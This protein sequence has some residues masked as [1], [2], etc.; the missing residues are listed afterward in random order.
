MVTK[1][2]IAAPDIERDSGFIGWVMATM[3]HF[4]PSRG[5]GVAHD[6]LE[7]L[8]RRIGVE[9][10][11]EAFGAIL[12]IRGDSGYWARSLERVQYSLCNYAYQTSGDFAQ[13]LAQAGFNI[14]ARGKTRLLDEEQEEQLKD[15]PTHY[16]RDV[17]E[18]WECYN[19]SEEY[20]GDK[21][22]LRV[23]NI[24]LDW[25]RAGYRRAERMYTMGCDMTAEMFIAIEREVDA[26]GEPE[27]GDTLTVTF[28]RTEF[29]YK[30][31]RKTP[32]YNDW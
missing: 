18:E 8:T 32:H 2:F 19:G 30:I 20:P 11:M 1:K 15:L 22:A 17:Q 31:T 5:L 6:C 28:S 29:D 13:F 26:L 12:F 14:Q 3:P 23:L 4:D 27:E 16:L 9:S 10:E 24:A 7:H 25:V 21:E